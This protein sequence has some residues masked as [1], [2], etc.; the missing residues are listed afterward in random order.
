MGGG[1][2][3]VEL[4]VGSVGVRWAAANEHSYCHHSSLTS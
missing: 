1:P 2:Y 4:E 3:Q